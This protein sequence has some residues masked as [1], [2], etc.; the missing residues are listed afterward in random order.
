MPFHIEVEN[1]HTRGIGDGIIDPNRRHSDG[2]QITTRYK[3][4]RPAEIS[5]ELALDLEASLATCVAHSRMNEGDIFK[6]VAL[7]GLHRAFMICGVRLESPDVICSRS[8]GGQEVAEKS[9]R[10]D[11][12][13]PGGISSQKGDR[14]WLVDLAGEN[15]ASRRAVRC[16]LRHA[17][18]SEFISPDQTV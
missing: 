15:S 3:A 2:L 4:A 13:A 9:S 10:V 14:I 18:D 16:G 17:V 11:D 8:E 5:P 7:D 12:I 6:I 1:G